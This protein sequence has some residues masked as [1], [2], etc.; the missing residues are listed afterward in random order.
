MFNLN[1]I[2]SETKPLVSSENTFR[3]TE[4]FFWKKPLK[5]VQKPLLQKKIYFKPWKFIK[6]KKFCNIW[7]KMVQKN[8]FK[9]KKEF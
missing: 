9:N 6:K 4:N 3:E 8:R 2:R 1:L 5:K 7:P